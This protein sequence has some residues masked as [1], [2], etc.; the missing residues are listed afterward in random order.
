MIAIIRNIFEASSEISKI[1]LKGKCSDCGC[2]V[3][4]NITPT[5][6]GVGLPGGALSEFSPDRYFAECPDCYNVVSLIIH[7]FRL[8]KIKK[9]PQGRIEKEVLS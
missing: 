8:K 3:N 6:R 7:H 2:E 5:S 1:E 4:I 9:K